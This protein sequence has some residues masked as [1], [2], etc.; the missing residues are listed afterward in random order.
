MVDTINAKPTHWKRP[1][2]KHIDTNPVRDKRLSG[3][4][5]AIMYYVLSKPKGWK[6]QVFD[7]EIYFTKDSEYAIRKA[8][9]ELAALDYIALKAKP[10]IGKEFQGKY[11]SLVDHSKPKLKRAYKKSALSLIT[12]NTLLYRIS[13]L[14]FKDMADNKVY[15][16]YLHLEEY[17]MDSR[18][19]STP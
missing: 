6:I 11:Y 1:E 8:L 9:G 18:L 5:K 7:L 14:Q 2:L 13:F 19:V 15:L 16:N 3:L 17:Y 12:S 4:A 10:R